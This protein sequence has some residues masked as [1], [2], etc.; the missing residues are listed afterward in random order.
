MPA[1]TADQIENKYYAA[2]VRIANRRPSTYDGGAAF[3]KSRQEARD[4]LVECT[5]FWTREPK[6]T[7]LH[8]DQNDSSFYSEP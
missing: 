6:P 1:M 5:G 7:V 8:N 4:V 2:L 3:L